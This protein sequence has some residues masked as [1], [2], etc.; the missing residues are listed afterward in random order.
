MCRLFNV[1]A[2]AAGQIIAAN[3]GFSQEKGGKEPVV[4]RKAVLPESNFG[5]GWRTVL[6]LGTLTSGKTQGERI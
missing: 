6:D 4:I 1:V 3:V 2:L 5:Q